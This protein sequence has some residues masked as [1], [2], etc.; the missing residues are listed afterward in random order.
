METIK[1]NKE[2]KQEILEIDLPVK[3]EGNIRGHWVWAWH[4]KQAHRKAIIAAFMNMAVKPQLPCNVTFI[5][6][7]PRF[8][9]AEENLPFAFK[10]QKDCIAG[11]LIPGKAPGRADGD[12]RIAW[13][14]K[15]EKSK[16]KGYR[17][18]FDWDAVT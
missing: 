8:L 13:H 4:R 6:L 11:L 15:Q 18:V 3:S 10:A 9:D 5:R 2:C 12:K 1:D 7:S 14:Y 16:L 17:I